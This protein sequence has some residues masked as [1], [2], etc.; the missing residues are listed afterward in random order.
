MGDSAVVNNS[1]TRI[2]GLY[3]LA[4]QDLFEGIKNSNRK[5]KI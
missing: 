4:L 5:F 3:L 1:N 2:P